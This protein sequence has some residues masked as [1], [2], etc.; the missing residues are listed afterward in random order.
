MS[1]SFKGSPEHQ[2]WEES[3]GQDEE[4]SEYRQKHDR[5][6]R[7]EQAKKDYDAAE[8]RETMRKNEEH[9]GR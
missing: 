4:E 3:G 8:D 2:D 5:R 1:N 9:L 7:S 6:E